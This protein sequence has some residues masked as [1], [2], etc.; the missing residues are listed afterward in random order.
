MVE[1]AFPIMS[2]K[3]LQRPTIAVCKQ[4]LPDW[5][6]ENEP[7]LVLSGQSPEGGIWWLL[8][9]IVGISLPTPF[10]TCPPGWELL[11]YATQ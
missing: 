3:L 11:N 4:C 9:L 2:N 6:A 8:H 1:P 10:G 7:G 5:R